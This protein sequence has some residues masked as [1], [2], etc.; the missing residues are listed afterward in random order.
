MRNESFLSGDIWFPDRVVF[1]YN[2]NYIKLTRI[3][4]FDNVSIHPDFTI[5]HPKTGKFFYWEH[6]GTIEKGG[7]LEM[8]L[9]KIRIYISNGLI[10]G[11][12][13]IMTFETQNYPLTPQKIKE[14]IELYF[15]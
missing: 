11:E 13:F 7:Y 1:V 12:N 2:P 8:A 4:E 9:S 15:G 5:R 14:I 3:T 10:P 6:F